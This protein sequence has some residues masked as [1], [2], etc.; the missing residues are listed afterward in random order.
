[1]QTDLINAAVFCLL[2]LCDRT[3]HCLAQTFTEQSQAADLW[4]NTTIHI[5]DITNEEQTHRNNNTRLRSHRD[6]INMPDP[7]PVS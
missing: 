2:V 3:T 4:T 5:Q 6:V 7:R 1:M